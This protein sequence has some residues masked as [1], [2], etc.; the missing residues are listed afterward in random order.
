MR[1]GLAL[2]EFQPMSSFALAT[3][4]E[5]EVITPSDILGLRNETLNELLRGSGTSHLVSDVEL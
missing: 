1:R 5:L 4:F 3:H 2:K